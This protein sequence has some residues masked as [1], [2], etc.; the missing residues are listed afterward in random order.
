MSWKA[1]LADD[2]PL[3]REDLA[4]RLQQC[5]PEL[6][7]A[8]TAA[9]GREALELA[10]QMRPDVAFLDIRMPGCSGLE[11]ASALDPRVHVVFVTAYDQYALQ[12]FEQAAVDYLLKPVSDA[13]LGTTVQ[14]LRARLEA[15][16]PAPD[17]VSLARRLLAATESP[18][19]PVRFVRVSSGTRTL[20]LPVTDVVY[21]QADAKYT[22]VLTAEREYLSR[23]ALRELEAVLDPERFWRV[24]RSTIVNMDRVAEAIRDER[25]RW[26]LRL[27]DRPENV[28]V[29]DSYADRLRYR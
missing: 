6:E 3:L 25:G 29:S 17:A 4:W 21:F 5:W 26:Q 15:A 20:L 28:R 9:D 19:A 7:L 10:A 22:S 16:S 27:R 23:T 8:A 11:V 12:A 2:E 14:R 18:A 13:R 1:L 24:H